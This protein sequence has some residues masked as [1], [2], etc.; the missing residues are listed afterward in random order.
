MQSI[1]IE[2]ILE[3]QKSKQMCLC[4]VLK[5]C[6]KLSVSVQIMN[7]ASVLEA[8]W[9]EVCGGRQITVGSPAC[10]EVVQAG[11]CTRSIF[12]NP[13]KREVQGSPNSSKEAF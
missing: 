10:L 2:N 1:C 12:T 5:T 13:Q 6:F 8:A 11:R 4:L 7:E 3:T 9:T